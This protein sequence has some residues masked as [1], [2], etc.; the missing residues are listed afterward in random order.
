[1]SRTVATA[2]RPQQAL[3]SYLDALLQEAAAELEQSIT[4]DEFEAAVIEEQ[5]RDARLTPHPVLA[6]GRSAAP[7]LAHYR[8]AACRQR[9]AG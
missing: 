8:I 6:A 4:L 5:V 3:Q 1:M 2:T 9:A 7:G